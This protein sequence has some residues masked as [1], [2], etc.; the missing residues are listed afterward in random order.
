MV[1]EDSFYLIM[2]DQTAA[3][4]FLL[5]YAKT[6]PD[7]PKPSTP[8]WQ[9]VNENKTMILSR[10]ERYDSGKYTLVINDA[11]G[12]IKTFFSLQLNIEGKIAPGLITTQSKNVDTFFLLNVQNVSVHSVSELLLHVCL[13]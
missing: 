12:N 7:P 6:Q 3:D 2:S 10:A 1:E 9:F 11:V 13:A 8:R 4:H 5:K